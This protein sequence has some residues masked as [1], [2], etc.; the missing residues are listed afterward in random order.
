MWT[1]SQA[2]TRLGERLAEASQ[3]FWPDK[4]RDDALND[5]QRFIAAV[6][7]GVPLELSGPV[8]ANTPYLVVTGKLLGPY[9][10]AGR[11]AAG[12][13]LSF[14]PIEVAD[15]IYPTWASRSGFPRWV[16]TAPHESRVYLTPIPDDPVEVS[17]N[18][19]VLPPDLAQDGAEFFLGE[20]VMEKYLGPL[21]NLAASYCLLKE[22]YDGDAER[23]YSMAIQEL[24][25]LGV[26]PATI[27][28]RPQQEAPS[29]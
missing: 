3:V 18:V 19:S 6:T 23:F 25:T 27:P 29:E 11:G 17:V 28:S 8:D 15:R 14:I 4:E 12:R 21:L 10:A 2:R 13:A 5:A 9:P 16:V 7:R 24:S 22:R 20:T 1:L 26:D